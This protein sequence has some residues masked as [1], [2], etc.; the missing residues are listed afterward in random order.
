MRGIWLSTFVLACLCGFTELS[1]SNTAW[2]SAAVRQARCFV[3]KLA[4]APVLSAAQKSAPAPVKTVSSRLD[5]PRPGAGTPVVHTAVLTAST[6]AMPP[7]PLP[8]NFIRYAPR[9]GCGARMLGGQFQ[10]S[11]DGITYVST[12]HDCESSAVWAMERRRCAA[13]P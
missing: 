3:V 13:G 6:S 9:P 5:R 12:L 4:P 11:S 2:A 10:G 1:G 7:M 8:I